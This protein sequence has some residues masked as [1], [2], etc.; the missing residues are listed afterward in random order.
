M[1]SAAIK[2]CLVAVGLICWSGLASA[3]ESRFTT[4]TLDF[5]EP[6]EAQ[7]TVEYDLLDL[8]LALGLD[9]DGDGVI[10]W[11]EYDSR[12]GR[13]AAYTSRSLRLS[14]A[15]ASC[16][17][18][19]QHQ[20]GG[21]R[22]GS[23]P[24]IVMVYRLECPRAVDSVTLDHHLLT[25]IDPAAKA[26][27]R[28]IGAGAE[29]SMVLAAGSHRVDMRDTGLLQANASFVREG[30]HHILIGYDHLAFLLLLILPAARQGSNRERL[31]AVMGIVT[32]FTLAHSVTLALSATGLVSLP[33]KM[34]ESV[35]AAS[36]ILAGLINLA[37][38]L[39][40]LG[41]LIAYAFGLVHGFGFA[42]ALT[43]LAIAEN[44][45]LSNLAA[46]NVGVEIGQL[47]IVLL[48]LPLLFLLGRNACWYR[49]VVRA[50]S[51]LVSAVGGI[52]L[53]ERIG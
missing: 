49:R 1:T 7:V 37:R 16:E 9:E 18:Q 22:A 46:F 2:L 44:L 27:L 26:M 48:V 40:R 45:R 4:L 21:V 53:L 32:A 12:R 38:P 34:I 15:Q 20:S 51:L 10:L 14:A 52:W 47:A 33:G 50:L 23:M 13:I 28:V 6:Q 39:H 30:I 11:H 3:H 19:P 25:D 5:S 31:L 35:I 24:S 36:V 42:G 41:W 29:K 43:E 17:L 8:G